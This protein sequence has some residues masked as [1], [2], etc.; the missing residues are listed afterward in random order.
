MNAVS[1]RW[2]G[3]YRILTLEQVQELS[4]ALRFYTSQQLSEQPEL[5]AQM[6]ILYGRMPVAWWVLAKQLLWI[7]TSYAGVEGL[8]T[9]EGIAHP[10]LLT[11][12]RIHGETI[13]EHLFGML[14]SLFRQ[15]TCAYRQQ[16]EQRW[17][18]IGGIDILAGKTLGIVGTGAIGRRAAEIGKAFAMRVLGLRVHDLPLAPFDAIYTTE[19]L[20]EFLPQC[21]VVMLTL[22]LTA[23]TRR[24][25][26][27]AEL[28][29]MK[30]G[31]VLLNI[32]RGQLIDTDTLVDALAAGRLGGAAL[33]VTNPE[34]LPAEHP[35]WTLPN[36]LITPHIAGSY[37]GYD[38]D[39]AELFL[40][41]LRRFLAG[42]ELMNLVDK[43][44]GY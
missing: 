4:P 41:N 2:Y 3:V 7:Q 37:P 24:I 1:F 44:A 18:R 32:G 33:D 20:H 11:N 22:P 34:P 42:E 9:P 13:S 27:A 25:I 12:A 14:L 23:R 30:P 26:G 19:R 43:V 35:L 38:I 40:A 5:I 8:L 39:A 36:V 16:L 6:H 29:V 21:D 28:A 10:A 17:S 15:L 31:A